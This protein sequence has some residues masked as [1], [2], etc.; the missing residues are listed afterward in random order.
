[1]IA[2]YLFITCW[3]ILQHVL[4]VD[5]SIM[6]YAGNFSENDYIE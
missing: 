1:M 3:N 2:E 5:W 6:E 4:D